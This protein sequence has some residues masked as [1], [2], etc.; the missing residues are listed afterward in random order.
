MSHLVCADVP[1]SSANGMQ[2]KRFVGM[3]ACFPRVPRSLAAS[4][5][6]F[7]G[8]DYHFELIRL[9]ASLYGIAPY[10]GNWTLRPV[11]SLDARIVQIRTVQAGDGVGGGPGCGCAGPLSGNDRL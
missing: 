6:I 3:A 10:K 5:G 4:S 1:D 2:R 8:P 9:G 7:L 11:V